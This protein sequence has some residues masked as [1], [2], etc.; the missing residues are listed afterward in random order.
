DPGDLTIDDV[1]DFIEHSLAHDEARVTE[2]KSEQARTARLRRLT[3]WAFV[4]T[5]AVVVIAAGVVALIQWYNNQRLFLS[6]FVRD[7]LAATRGN[8]ALEDDDPSLAILFALDF[9]RQKDRYGHATEALAYKAL[10]TTQPKAIL[11]AEAPFPTVA[12]SPDGR[13]LL[14]SKGNAFQLWDTDK[15]LPVGKE[16]KPEGIEARWRTIWSPDA[17]WMV[18]SNVNKETALF[19]P[20]SVD[21]LRKYF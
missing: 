20:C 2:I 4:A 10:Q 8:E 12:F 14:I 1:Q 17:Q 3:R 15:I 21:E 5:T 6:A 9:L 16:F 11:L 13:L 7:Q 18:G 19:R